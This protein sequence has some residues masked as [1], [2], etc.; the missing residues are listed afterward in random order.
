MQMIEYLL[1]KIMNKRVEVEI[2]KTIPGQIEGGN[3]QPAG[4]IK[5]AYSTFNTIYR[6]F[7]ST[8]FFYQT[9]LSTQ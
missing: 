8:R 1:F 5:R 2:N 7:Q 6:L 4:N 9:F 3:K